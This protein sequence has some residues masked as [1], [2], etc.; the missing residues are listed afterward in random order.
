MAL[1]LRKALLTF[2]C[3]Y[4]WVW[5]FKAR[6]YATIR[7]CLHI[8]HERDFCVLALIP[9]S[10]KG[11]YIDIGANKGQSI[12]SI[13]LFKPSADV[14]S[15]EPNPLLAQKLKKRYGRQANVRV[16]P[17]GLSD[18]VGTFSLFVPCYGRLACDELASLHKE[19]AENWI[20]DDR[21]FG[22]DA[23]N[24]QILEV[25]CDVSMLDLYRL[26]PVFIKVDVQ[27][28]EYNVLAGAQETLR[29]CEPILLIEDYRGNPNTV[30]L[31][32]RLG[33]EEVCLDDL[34]QRKIG[35][36]DNSLLITP[37]RKLR[38]GLS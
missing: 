20:N 26:S 31:M 22:F 33:Y 34:M 7:R 1:P 13:L 15:F 3:I 21:V 18:E 17:K 24:L 5:D 29:R 9:P 38:L 16:I 25:Q 4:P 19:A 12:E 6:V 28:A 11:C 23:A 10:Q 30:N 32:E 27:G 37:S 2:G 36:R 35:R 14:F 8:P